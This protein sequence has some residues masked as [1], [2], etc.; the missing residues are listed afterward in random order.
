VLADLLKKRLLTCNT[1]VA[2]TKKNILNLSHSIH[3]LRA[4]K[5]YYH[6]ILK[7]LFKNILK[8]YNRGGKLLK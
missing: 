3:K 5:N 2:T 6:V 4:K 8:F 1:K 7:L